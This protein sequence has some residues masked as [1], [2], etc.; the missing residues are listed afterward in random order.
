ML[1]PEPRSEVSE[2][3]SVLVMGQDGD[4][5]LLVALTDLL[6]L[7]L[8]A[9]E[10]SEVSEVLALL[11]DDALEASEAP[12]VEDAVFFVLV[13]FFFLAS[14]NRTSLHSSIIPSCSSD[15]TPH[16]VHG[17]S[18]VQIL[19]AGQSG[20]L[21][22]LNGMNELHDPQRRNTGAMTGREEKEEGGV[23]YTNAVNNK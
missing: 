12:L 14:V 5:P 4:P 22:H 9:L 3:P 8:G 15:K 18:G 16:V 17:L 23:W 11:A 21:S 20:C 10:V 2:T 13:F 19:H 6:L 7:L 1:A